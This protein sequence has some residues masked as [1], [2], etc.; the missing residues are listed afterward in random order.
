VR[1]FH[2]DGYEVDPGGRAD[3]RGD[4]ALPGRMRLVFT[5]GPR[6]AE[7]IA[8]GPTAYL[9][10]NQAFYV[11]TGVGGPALGL[12][13][14][15][16]VS[17]PASSTPG[18]AQFLALTDP[19]T[20]GRC[21]IGPHLGTLSLAGR[22]T[23]QGRAALIVQDAGDRAGT[24]PSRFYL[25]ASGPPLPLRDQL[26]GPVRPGGQPD[27]GCHETEQDLYPSTMS[28]DLEVSRYDDPVHISVPA[29]AVALASLASGRGQPA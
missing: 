17:T 7:V 22:A 15:R 9:R 3:F 14:G 16:W 5:Q 18:F 1:S 24:S 28:G 2:I 19:A 27:A 25:A 29:G 4:F 11:S 10:A 8:I 23:V 26:L 21:L 13:A 12:V 20:V 6:R